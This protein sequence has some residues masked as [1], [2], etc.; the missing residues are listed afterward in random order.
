MK[1]AVMQP[2]FFPYAGYWQLIIAADSLV[3]LDDTQ[4]TRRGWI[5]RNR[6][7]KPAGGWQYVTVPLERHSQKEPIRNI[8][9]HETHDW[10]NTILRQ[11]DHYKRKAPHFDAT[12]AIVRSILRSALDR[13]ISQIN[14]TVVQTM[15]AALG[16]KRNVMVSSKCN[17]DYSGVAEAGDWALRISEQLQ[18]AEYINPISGA[19]LYNADAFAASNVRL[20]FLRPEEIVYPQ[21]GPFEPWLSII[22]L[23]MFNGIEGTKA[24]LSRY[25]LCSSLE[26]EMTKLTSNAMS[27]IPER[28]SFRRSS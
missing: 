4:Y 17:F 16:I 3:L 27:T 10:K 12:I 26:R 24:L 21:D 18:A 9:A 25:S 19:A 2:Y 1:L 28:N 22:D 8:R 23:L 6:I 20:S 7:L 15:C 11:L 13:R 14:F 5:N